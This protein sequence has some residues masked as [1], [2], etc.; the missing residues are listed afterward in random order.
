[1][2]RTGIARSTA[3]IALTSALLAPAALPATTPSTAPLV[4]LGVPVSI[5][6]TPDRPDLWRI[7]PV[8]R[9]GDRVQ[10]AFDNTLSG[11]SVDLCLM[12]PVDDFGLDNEV[13]AACDD[14]REVGISGS[15]RDRVTITYARA[16]GQPIL[17]VASLYDR[18]TD[19]SFTVERV[20]P[21]VA[22]GT[23]LS[24][25][26]RTRV[27]VRGNA[28]FGDNTP[29]SDGYVAQLRYRPPGARAFTRVLSTGSFRGGSVLLQGRIPGTAVGKRVGLQLCVLGD[30]QEALACAART[31]RVRR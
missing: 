26:T 22:L 23:T 4:E 12:Q 14:D 1:M 20:I 31:V 8:V 16:T 10:I 27:S 7:A 19:Y 2:T 21:K 24:S 28:R 15:S 9:T 17:R 3:A 13:E 11:R 29:V 6:G 5:T 18:V 25:S 30:A